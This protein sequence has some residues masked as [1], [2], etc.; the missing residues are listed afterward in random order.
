M[1]FD[2]KTT[3]PADFNEPK[4]KISLLV[5]EKAE[6]CCRAFLGKFV[7]DFQVAK[8]E[9]YL[10]GPAGLTAKFTDSQMRELTARFFFFEYEHVVVEGGLVLHTTEE[11]EWI[12]TASTGFLEYNYRPLL[13]F[14]QKAVEKKVEADISSVGNN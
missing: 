4:P 13:S 11:K 6:L 3:E 8:T 10:E 14:I 7:P 9:C 5:E 1:S 2:L 12:F